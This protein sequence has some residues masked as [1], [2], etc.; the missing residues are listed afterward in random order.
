MKKS[1]IIA[2]ATLL[3]SM[4]ESCA[5]DD[6]YDDISQI[7]PAEAKLFSYEAEI[8]AIIPNL[9]SFN[10]HS[11]Q[12]F[13]VYG[14]IAFGFYDT[15]L[16]RCIDLNKKGIIA[17]FALPKGV[18]HSSNHAGVACFSNEFLSED[19]EFPLL[20]LSSYKERKC[21]VLRLMKDNAELVQTI[22]TVD[23]LNNNSLQDVWAYEPDGNVLLLKTS[24]NNDN[25]KVGYNWIS[26]RKPSINEGHDICLDINNKIDE[27]ITEST[28]TY[29]AGFVHNGYIYQLAGYTKSNRK[30]YI[31]D[32]IN[33]KTIADITWNN[34]II[35]N[36]EQEQCSR[37]K[38]GILINYNYS[39]KLVYVKFNNWTF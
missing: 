13:A 12:G 21:Y 29:N 3:L 9:G 17:E 38:D 39:D 37:Y 8:F 16:C 1:F 4:T 7:T 36:M 25:N 19:D 31:L 23:S 2:L 22:I 28:S 33:K 34:S 14:D 6:I 26:M 27:Y 18:N 10:N 32:Y 15:G 35:N 30:L 20:Y 5:H 11:F 24:H